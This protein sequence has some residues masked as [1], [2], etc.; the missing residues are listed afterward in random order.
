MAG[1]RPSRCQAVAGTAGH[2]DLPAGSGT[3]NLD[4]HGR[5]FANR[6][7]KCA[8]NYNDTIYLFSKLQSAFW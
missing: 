6:K 7:R 3:Q 2:R 4:R 8:E 5:D 1:S